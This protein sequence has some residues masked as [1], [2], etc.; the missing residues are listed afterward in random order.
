M[1]K[2]NLPDELAK[3]IDTL[4]Q[5]NI[6]GI[7]SRDEFIRESVRINLERYQ[8]MLDLKNKIGDP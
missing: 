1:A 7:K 2:L 6:F 8:K 3:E 4:K 5:R